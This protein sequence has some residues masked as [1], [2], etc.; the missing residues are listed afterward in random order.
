MT[1]ILPALQSTKR[2]FLFSILQEN[3][4]YLKTKVPLGMRSGKKLIIKEKFQIQRHNIS[5][6]S[7]LFHSM[8]TVFPKES[9]ALFFSK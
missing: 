7:I 2:Q 4:N 1:F 5:L 8:F 3:G 6:S 9:S